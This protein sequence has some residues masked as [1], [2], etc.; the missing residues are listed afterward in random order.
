MVVS[1]NWLQALDF[2]KFVT[3]NFDFF[4]L[5]TRESAALSVVGTVEGRATES[6]LSTEHGS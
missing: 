6:T 2:F 4:N 5:T 1:F 3:W